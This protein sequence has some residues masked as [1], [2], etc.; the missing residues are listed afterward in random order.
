MCRAGGEAH[1]RHVCATFRAGDP[2]GAKPA[3][4]WFPAWLPKAPTPS[5]GTPFTYKGWRPITLNRSPALPLM[6]SLI[7][8]DRTVTLGGV[9]PGQYTTITP[10]M[11]MVVDGQIR[12]GGGGAKS[13][14][15]KHA[16]G[17][18]LGE[19]RAMFLISRA[20]ARL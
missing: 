5:Q 2:T 4:S 10:T 1:V 13:S 6:P 14:L 15:K 16:I 12:E 19:K 11:S 7:W 20:C 8:D 3:A 9:Q 18:K 17:E